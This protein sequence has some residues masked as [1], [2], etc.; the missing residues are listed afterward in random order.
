MRN[1]H[2]QNPWKELILRA[3]YIFTALGI[4]LFRPLVLDAQVAVHHTEGLHHGF[5]ELS[6]LDG[7]ILAD[8]EQTQ[9][10]RGDQVTAH[11]I[12]RFK[13][14]SIH[15]ETTVF[16]QHQNFKLPNTHLRWL[17]RRR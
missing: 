5:L 4:A 14:G 11:L 7:E 16:S 3:L 1:N 17:R 2:A 15:E 9:I 10:A 13:D 8:G 6:T 12:F